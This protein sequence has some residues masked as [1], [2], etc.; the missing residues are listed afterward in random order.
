LIS[1]KNE[2]FILTKEELF[3]RFGNGAVQLKEAIE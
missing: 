3:E 2:D 1:P